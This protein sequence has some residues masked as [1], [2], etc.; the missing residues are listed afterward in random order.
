M[1]S[2]H[3]ALVTAAHLEAIAQLGAPAT[4]LEAALPPRKPSRVAAAAAMEPL[5]RPQLA[6]VMVALSTHE[7]TVALALALAAV[8]FLVMCRPR[9]AGAGAGSPKK[10]KK[11]APKRAREAAPAASASAAAAPRA[12]AA[13]RA[14]S[15]LPADCDGELALELVLFHNTNR[16]LAAVSQGVARRWAPAGLAE[17]ARRFLGR[18]RAGTVRMPPVPRAL[19]PGS[20]FEH[21]LPVQAADD[22]ALA[23]AVLRGGAE[24]AAA[25]APSGAV[26][27][28]R[29]L[30]SS[31]VF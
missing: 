7:N 30:S 3:D 29:P 22:S 11:K 13:A 25:A 19:A 23:Q 4:A 8:A 24:D 27:P 12:P 6:L 26:A 10:Q 15:S 16:Q 21:D 5:G 18:R 17:R 31:R 9:L 1:E 14:V 20:L 2:L 28:R